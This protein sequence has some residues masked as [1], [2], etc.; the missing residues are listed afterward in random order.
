[1]DV[2]LLSKYTFTYVFPASS[3]LSNIGEDGYLLSWFK[4]SDGNKN[5]W[6]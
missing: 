4:M 5:D 2:I 6:Y 1:L 3:N